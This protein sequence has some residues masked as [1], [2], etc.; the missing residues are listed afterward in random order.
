MPSQLEPLEDGV[1]KEPSLNIV[2]QD[3]KSCHH[4]FL[5]KGL[6][7]M[8][9]DKCGWGILISGLKDYEKIVSMYEKACLT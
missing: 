4:K 5:L 2:T 8:Y 3:A 6:H 9:C 7:D 1:N